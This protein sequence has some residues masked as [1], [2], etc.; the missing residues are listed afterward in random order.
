[1]CG[2]QIRVCIDRRL[3][4]AD[5]VR[6]AERAVAEREGNAPGDRPAPSTW[7]ERVRLAVETKKRWRPGRT[8]RVRFLDGEPE[9]HRRVRELAAEWM[10][11]AH[12]KLDFGDDPAA[13]LRVAFQPGGSWSWIGTEAFTVAPA[14]PTMNLGW[15]TGETPEEDARRVVLHEFGH[16]LGCVHEHMNPA[17]G[18]PWDREAVYAH[19]AEAQGWD[20][21]A[22]DRN[23]FETYSADQT[24]FT[25]FDPLSIMLYPIPR[26]LTLNGFEAGW[27]TALSATDATF[28][29]QIYPIPDAALPAIALDGPVLAGGIPEP[30]AELRYRF[31]LVAPAHVVME[32]DG[33]T[34][35]ELTV[36]GPDNLAYVA[37][38]DAGGGL[39]GNARVEAVLMPGAYVAVVRHQRATGTGPFHLSLRS[40]S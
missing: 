25:A 4:T 34:D 9:V 22:V 13:E 39:G 35:L 27:N 23:V 33:P 15:L 37:G 36:R 2:D 18:I 1:M 7:R 19:Y 17:G 26:E 14:E 20:R 12:V 24:Q 6:A 5:T 40:A 32:T 16:A 8:L 11:H 30:G 10:D 21:V 3:G 31:E 29:G 28:I 38:R